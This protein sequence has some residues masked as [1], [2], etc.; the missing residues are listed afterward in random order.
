MEFRTIS[1][2]VQLVLSGHGRRLK[3]VHM[4]PGSKGSEDRNTN[5][6][7]V[8]NSEVVFTAISNY[9]KVEVNKGHL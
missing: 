7:S 2:S 6:R 3:Q 9:I 4:K 8:W 5:G 1:L